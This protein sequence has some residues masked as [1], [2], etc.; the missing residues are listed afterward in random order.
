MTQTTTVHAFI[1]QE[2]L[3]AAL[4]TEIG[5]RLTAALEARGN[6]TLAVS[7]G[8]TPKPLF[9]RLHKLKLDWDKIHI[10]LVDERWVDEANAASNAAL[11]RR[12][13]L[14]GRAAEAAFLGLKSLASSP[15]E[16]VQLAEQ[17]LRQLELPFD[18]VLLGM[19]QDGHFAS[20]FPGMPGLE[21][22]LNPNGRTLYFS[23]D[24]PETGQTRL[25]LTLAGLLDSRSWILHIEG[26]GKW[27]RLGD[28]MTPGP[29]T[30]LPARALLRQ[31][32]VPL[33]IYYC[34]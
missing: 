7:G 33:D 3:L 23:A 15:R 11:V 18:L 14:K 32:R 9:Q 17:R 12:T 26:A 28:A 10:T 21:R 1:D 34:P 16:R 31:Q 29:V 24:V 8:S 6:A 25:S 13:L 5:E 4:C 30:A 2:D 19:G 22:A 27:Q 20:L